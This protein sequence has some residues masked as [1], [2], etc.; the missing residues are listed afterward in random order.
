M[1]RTW[2]SVVLTIVFG[3]ATIGF[4]HGQPFGLHADPLSSLGCSYRRIRQFTNPYVSPRNTPIH[5]PEERAP[6]AASNGK[7][8]V[9]YVVVL[10]CLLASAAG[11]ACLSVLALAG[12]IVRRQQRC[13]PGMRNTGGKYGD[14]KYGGIR[15]QTGRSPVFRPMLKPDR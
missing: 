7:L 9:A 13:D 14:R 12:L 6:S 5:D 15:G 10:E 3:L 1:G 11:T 4:A 8:I 2:E